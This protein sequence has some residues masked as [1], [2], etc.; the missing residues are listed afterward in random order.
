MP[1]SIAPISA[2]ACA[3]AAEAQVGSIEPGKRADFLV[4]SADYAQK[5]VFLAGNPL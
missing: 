5:R 3:I 1:V 4:C 2:S